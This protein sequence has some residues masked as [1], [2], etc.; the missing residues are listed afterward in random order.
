MAQDDQKYCNCGHT[1]CSRPDP[2]IEHALKS[3][4][5]VAFSPGDLVMLKSGGPDM[6][7]VSLDD[8]RPF[9][10]AAWF[11]ESGELRVSLYPIAAVQL[12]PKG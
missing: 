6:T 4:N 12:A 1:G 8:T 2:N 5:T 9:L 11:V 10:Q 7:I 3:L